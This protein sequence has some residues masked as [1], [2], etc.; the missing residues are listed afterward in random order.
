MAVLQGSSQAAQAV[1]GWP[2]GKY[3]VSFQAAQRSYPAG[4]ARQTIAVLCDGVQVGSI[5]P[6][7]TSYQPC[8]SAPF[9]VAAGDHTIAL[10][11]TNT[12]GDHAA[13][14]DAVTIAAAPAAIL[15]DP[16]FE[17]PSVGY[18]Q[19]ARAP[20]GG[21]WTF[22]G[23][24][25]LAGNGSGYTAANP[26]APQGQQV[27]YMQG[28]AAISQTIAAAQAGSYQI[29]FGAA[30]RN[31]PQAGSNQ[32]VSVLLDGQPI[33]AIKPIGITY[34]TYYAPLLALAE[35]DH[36]LTFETPAAASDNTAFLDAVKLTPAASIVA[37]VQLADA[38]IGSS[39][40][41]AGFRFQAASGS[42]VAAGHPVRPAAPSLS[43][44]PGPR[45]PG[46]HGRPG[47]QRG[48]L[49]PAGAG[50]SGGRRR[51]DHGLGPARLV[52]HHGGPG[53]GP[54]GRR[55]R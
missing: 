33:A 7:G 4:G 20:A 39:G 28:A 10:A 18:G 11:G 38:W 34:Q 27:A 53:R 29:S 55:G 51:R 8:S 25:G 37:A 5:A 42:K 48:C 26:A 36:A 54:G 31:Y 16:G 46:G 22:G 50:R 15:T 6:S 14:I 12:S 30:Q 17:V 3:Q 49:V 19:F 47:G 2:A 52:Q 21:A 24:A 43:Q 32:V 41:T 1:A 23:T 40:K 44:R 13:F 35:G 9:T 45:S